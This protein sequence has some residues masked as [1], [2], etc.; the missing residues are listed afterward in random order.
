LLLVLLTAPVAAHPGTD[1]AL[2]RPAAPAADAPLVAVT[3]TVAEL[4]VE[5]RLSNRTLRY[6][7]LRTDQG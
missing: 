7:A 4:I 6:L 2:A 3:G 5:D 1:A